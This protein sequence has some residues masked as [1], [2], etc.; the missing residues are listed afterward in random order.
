MCE[1]SAFK[2]KYQ[3]RVHNNIC[4]KCC[5][6]LTDLRRKCPTC[7]LYENTWRKTTRSRRTTQERVYKQ[8]TWA[9]R[10]VM[11]AKMADKRYNRPICEQEYIT[12]KRLTY[13]RLL[14]QNRCFYCKTELQNQNRKLHNGLSCERL[15]SSESHTQQNC[16]L[17]CHRC[18][19]K[20]M[21]RFNSK[22]GLCT[23]YD[24]F[25][26]YKNK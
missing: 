17:A 15:S 25:L 4:V 16:V 26:E 3:A 20:R 21:D 13:L 8:N 11:H 10:I 12:P 7:R 14:Q 23:F 5:K 22:T 2:R 24:L 6:T 18:N 9:K 19:C 1:T